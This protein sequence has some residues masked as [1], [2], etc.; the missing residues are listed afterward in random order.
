MNIQFCRYQALAKPAFFGMN[1]GDSIHH[2]HVVSGE[3]GVAFTEQ[4]AVTTGDDFL[5]GIRVL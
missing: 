3:F 2:Q 1:A 5:A 4:V